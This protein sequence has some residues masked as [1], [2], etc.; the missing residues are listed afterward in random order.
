MNIWNRPIANATVLTGLHPGAFGSVRKHDIH[1][2]IDLY[3]QPGTEVFAA[4]AGTVV[5]VVNFT[6]VA[7]DS[8]W[9]NDTKAVM[10]EGVSGVILYGEIEECVMVGDKILA[11][12]IIGQVKTVLKNNKGKPMTM[13]HLELYAAG[14]TLPVWWHHSQPQPANLIDPT[15]QLIGSYDKG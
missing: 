10:I 14:T 15:Q 1:T 7:A 8:P 3:C 11:G 12:Q 2:G 5:S 9:W 13:L 4:E 6:G